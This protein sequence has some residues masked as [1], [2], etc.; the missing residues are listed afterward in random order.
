MNFSR[1][2]SAAMPGDNRR[3]AATA[4]EGTARKLGSRKC[5]ERTKPIAETSAVRGHAGK[6]AIEAPQAHHQDTNRIIGSNVRLGT[7]MP[8]GLL[9]RPS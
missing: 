6:T 2:A 1:S 9:E 3:M 8:V 5:G 4:E 7:E